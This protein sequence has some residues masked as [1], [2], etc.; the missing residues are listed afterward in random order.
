MGWGRGWS[1]E[2]KAGR[3]EEGE[4]SGRQ[5]SAQGFWARAE[6][7]RSSGTWLCCPC[8]SPDSRREGLTQLCQDSSVLRCCHG[9]NPR[10]PE[11]QRRGEWWGWETQARPGL[12]PVPSAPVAG[13][14]PQVRL[15]RLKCFSCPR[16]IPSCTDGLCPC[17]WLMRWVGGLS[18]RRAAGAEPEARPSP[19]PRL[20]EGG[21]YLKG[22]AAVPLPVGALHWLPCGVWSKDL[23]Y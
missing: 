20:L 8:G 1:A 10:F 18:G 5:E 22:A 19:T 17:G 12:T 7:K 15:P 9:Q 14:L 11:H 16:S 4:A 6:V 2:C 23:L 3:R 13:T 21:E